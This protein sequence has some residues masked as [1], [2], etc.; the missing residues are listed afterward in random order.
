MKLCISDLWFI[1]KT[2][3]SLLLLLLLLLQKLPTAAVTI[4][5]LLTLVSVHSYVSI[6][7]RSI[8]FCPLPHP[9]RLSITIMAFLYSVLTRDS[10]CNLLSIHISFSSKMFKVPFSIPML[11][12]IFLLVTLYDESNILSTVAHLYYCF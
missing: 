6:V 4:F 12:W 8:H 9:L 11:C 1:E 2:L 5:L 7:F 3:L 10:S